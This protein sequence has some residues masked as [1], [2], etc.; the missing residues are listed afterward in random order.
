M[1]IDIEVVTITL[2]R[3]DIALE[4]PFV[5]RDGTKISIGI[6]QQGTL[7]PYPSEMS[8]SFELDEAMIVYRGLQEALGQ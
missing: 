4:Q 5:R 7:R 6:A 3:E 1:A 2:R 8:L